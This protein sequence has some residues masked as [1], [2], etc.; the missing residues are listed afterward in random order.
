MGDLLVQH[1]QAAADAVDAATGEA[2]PALLTLP[3]ARGA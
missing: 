2:S 1:L 3:A